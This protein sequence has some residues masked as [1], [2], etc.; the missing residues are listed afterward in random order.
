MTKTKQVRI[1]NVPPI[2]LELRSL[3]AEGSVHDVVREVPR[4]EMRRGAPSLFIK[5]GDEEIGLFNQ[6]YEV[7]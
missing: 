5:P 1:I 2:A 4:H 3:V 6:E 7:V